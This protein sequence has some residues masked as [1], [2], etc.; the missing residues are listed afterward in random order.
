MDYGFSGKS[1]VLPSSQGGEQQYKIQLSGCWL[2]A[3]LSRAKAKVYSIEDMNDLV[4]GME[5][6]AAKFTDMSQ[7]VR[8]TADRPKGRAVSLDRP[9]EKEKRTDKKRQVYERQSPEPWT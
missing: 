6:T 2:P 5:C 4:D 3:V 9:L 8:Q 1:A 7:V